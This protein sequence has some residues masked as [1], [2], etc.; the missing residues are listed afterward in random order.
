MSLI[1][2]QKMTRHRLGE[3]AAKHIIDEVFVLF[4][5][6]KCT[7]LELQVCCLGHNEDCGRGDSTSNSPEKLLQRGRMKGQ[8]M[9]NFGEEGIHAIKH[10]FFQNFPAGLMKL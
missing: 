7:T 9:F 6:K 8:Y 1:T 4:T 10:I 5:K 2:R 3:K